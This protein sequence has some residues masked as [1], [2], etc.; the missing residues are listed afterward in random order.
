M[1]S[2]EKGTSLTE[3]QLNSGAFNATQD[4][5]RMEKSRLSFCHPVESDTNSV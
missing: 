5:V 3:A 2:F 1:P 4:R